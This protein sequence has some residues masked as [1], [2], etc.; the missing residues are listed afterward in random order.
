[1][2]VLLDRDGVLNEDRPDFVKSPDELVLIP[3]AIEAVAKLTSHGHLCAIVTNQSCIGRGLITEDTLG[4]IHGKLLHAI[5]RAGGRIEHVFVAPEA[6]WAATA[7]RKPGSGMIT[8]A[9]QMFRFSASNTVMIGDSKRD[10]E[11]AAGPGCH[12]I[13]VQ[14]GKGRATQKAGLDKHILPVSVARDLAEATDFILQGRF[15]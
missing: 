9:L 10:L 1:V 8:S 5:T 3:G 4:Q 7:N 13:L 2:L 15:D 11:A 12:R 6:P 14:T